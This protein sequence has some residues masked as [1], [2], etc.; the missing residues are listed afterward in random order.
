MAKRKIH[1]MPKKVYQ[2]KVTLQESRPP[3]WR[4]VLVPGEATLGTLHWIIQAAMGWQN[5]HLHQFIIRTGR[6]EDYYADPEFELDDAEDEGAVKLEQL[7][8]RA[9]A[10]FYYEYDFGDGW[11]HLIQ[12]E[13]VLPPSEGQIYPR[14][15]AGALACPL[16]DSGGIY[17]YYDKLEI[18]RDPKH[19]EHVDIRD[20]VGEEFDPEAFDLGTVNRELAG[21]RW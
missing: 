16:E 13:K 10:R 18:L 12:I 14:C 21:I 20:W 2:M 15:L 6:H 5:S 19:E 3:I 9:P 8:P 17:G 11:H 4:R 7:F 1:R